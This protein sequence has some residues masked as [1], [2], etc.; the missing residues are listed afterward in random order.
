MSDTSQCSKAEKILYKGDIIVSI[1]KLKR[2][3]TRVLQ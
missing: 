3:D 1:V 2:Y